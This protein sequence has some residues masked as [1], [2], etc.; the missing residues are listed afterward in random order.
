MCIVDSFSEA[1]LNLFC[2]IEIVEDRY[3]ASVFFYD[4]GL[5]GRNERYIIL[6]FLTDFVVINIDIL[7]C[8][9]EEIA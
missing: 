3:F 6:Y 2:D 1:R 5:V 9:V 8:G 7:V 4:T